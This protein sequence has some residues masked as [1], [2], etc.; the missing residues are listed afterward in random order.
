MNSP[1]RT[2]LIASQK[3]SR[4]LIEFA[5][6]IAIRIGFARCSGAEPGERTLAEIETVASRLLAAAESYR[7]AKVL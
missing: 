5:A 1:L 3:A 4:D 7:L 6:R 2:Q